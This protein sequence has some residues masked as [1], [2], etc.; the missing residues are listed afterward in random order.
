MQMEAE[1]VEKYD[2]L[3]GFLN[4]IQVKILRTHVID[5]LRM[6]GHENRIDPDAW[7]P[8]IMSFQ[9]L[10]GLRSGKMEDSKLAKIDE[11]HYRLPKPAATL[12]PESGPTV[13]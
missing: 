7:H 13:E 9:H 4:V 11:E 5:Q 2:V 12:I 1:S 3:G 10:Y 6:R 8:M